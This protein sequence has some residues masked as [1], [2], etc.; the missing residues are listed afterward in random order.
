MIIDYNN[1]IPHIIEVSNEEELR[2]AMCTNFPGYKKIC[3]ISME[4]YNNATKEDLREMLS[5]LILLDSAKDAVIKIH[6]IDEVD[7]LPSLMDLYKD[8]DKNNPED[9]AYM[10]AIFDVIELIDKQSKLKNVL[11]NA[12]YY[13]NLGID[14]S[15]MF[16]KE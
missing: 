2:E 15:G 4:E 14:V 13:K 9:A 11:I 8:K 3:E 12:S 1:Y 10:S 16:N 6:S 5:D 7:I